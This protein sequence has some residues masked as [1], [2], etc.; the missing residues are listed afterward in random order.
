[1]FT[2]AV[3]QMRVA[4]STVLGRPFSVRVVQR[5][6][7]D[8][9]ATLEEFG[10]PGDDVGQLI[11]GPYADVGMRTALQTRA[12]QRTARHL[13]ARS[14][15]Y[16]DRF[17]A[18]GV[19]PA[20]LTPDT[21]LQL[22]LMTR[23]DLVSRQRD[24]LCGRPFL[25]TRS[26]GTTGVP[27][28]VWL[29]RHEITL[30]PSLIA[31]S[32]VLRGEITPDDHV[33]LS[34][35]SRATAAVQEDVEMC[36]LVG[37]ECSVIG[38]VP[39]DETLER[40]CGSVTVLNTYPS[41]LGALVTAAR[42]RGLGPADFA[43]HTI[44]AGGELMSSALVAAA[45]STFGARVNDAYGA[46]EV[47]PVGGRFCAHR[48]LHPDPNMGYAE[49]IDLS[50]GTPAAP[51]QLGTLVVTPYHPYRECM[52]V[53]RYD[54]RD[55]VRVPSADEPPCELAA[56]PA[57]SHI[58]GKA[59]DLLTTASGPVTPRDLVEVMDGLP[60][61]RWPV[62][63][64][65]AQAGARVRVTVPADHAGGLSGSEIAD[66]FAGHG[67][68]AEVA[69]TAMTEADAQRLRPLRCDLL[70]HTFTRSERRAPVLV[71]DPA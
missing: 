42:D 27:V 70:E 40:L 69:V 41:Y 22:P 15:F 52:P 44:N 50:T 8:A 14:S 43:L 60:G 2:T 21:L 37:A 12:L 29:S 11:D 4:F 56:I 61:A 35:S 23:A 49:V 38:L 9:L 24:L 55:L 33:Q 30:W 31:L 54:T 10:S 45:E 36:G 63:F 20:R 6:V 34:L 46:T 28:E 18:A 68:D 1:M 39:P 53:L 67:I 32:L 65:A 48:H 58:L 71:G 19:D 51:G 17:S 47:L 16:R 57:V 59:R 13:T 25:S 5:L 66:R 26:T 62:R 7:Q 3:R 64:A